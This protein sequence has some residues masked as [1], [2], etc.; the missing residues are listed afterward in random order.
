MTKE[1]V[2]RR[3]GRS[4]YNFFTLYSPLADEW[5]L[6]DNS[7]NDRAIRVASSVFN[8]ITIVETAIWQKLQRLS[9]AA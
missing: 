6:F 8:Q 2:R 9:N 3:F 7:S 5:T 4:L 1:I